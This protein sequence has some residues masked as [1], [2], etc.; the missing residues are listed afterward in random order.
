MT[1]E[2][3]IRQIVHE[4]LENLEASQSENNG[5]SRRG[6]LQAIGALGVGAGLGAAG[7]TAVETG[8][9]DGGAMHG[10]DQLGLESDRIGTIYASELDVD[11][12][13]QS[14]DNISADS[15]STGELNSIIGITSD[16][17]ESEV[18]TKISGISSGG[19]ALI[20][21][22]ASWT[23]T[24]TLTIPAGVTVIG[25]ASKSNTTAPTFEK[26][27]NGA[28]AERGRFV[29]LANLV[30]DGNRSSGYTG[31]GIVDSEQQTRECHYQNVTVRNCEGSGMQCRLNYLSTYDT[32]RF[33]DNGIG[34][35]YLDEAEH[36]GQNLWQ[37]CFVTG[38]DNAG[39]KYRYITRD[40][41]WIRCSIHGN[42]GPGI[43]CDTSSG[44]SFSNYLDR[45][46]Y[47]SDNDGPALLCTGTILG[48]IDARMASNLGSPD[49]SLTT[50][51]GDIHTEN[52]YF[53][54]LVYGGESDATT[55]LSAPNGP[56]GSGEL[57]ALGSGGDINFPT[58]FVT[59]MNDAQVGAVTAQSGIGLDPTGGGGTVTY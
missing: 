42:G 27:F 30:F 25:V 52:Q 16:L 5:T 56:S 6:V 39:Y 28:L 43:H 26:G 8:A 46:T 11:T 13:T 47:I 48:K 36:V 40:S 33:Q 23:L 7:Q 55:T 21:P 31:H 18:R 14:T 58:G 22:G 45:G 54:G 20:E 9:A 3:T 50:P 57:T 53:D 35:E 15:I 4:E 19:M 44:Q 34:V 12:F 32:C 49:S 37:N 41:S 29:T 2:A 10:I 1:D 17:S 38:N 24:D 59:V 51:V